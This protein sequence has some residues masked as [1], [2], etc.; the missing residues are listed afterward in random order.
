MNEKPASLADRAFRVLLRLLP[1]DIR[2][3]HGREMEQLFRAQRREIGGLRGLLCLWSETVQDVLTTAPLEHFHVLRQDVA[4]ALRILR[5]APGFTAAATITFA[6]GIGGATSV[7]TVVNAFVFRPLPVHRPGELVSIAALDSHF[8]MPHALSYPDLQDY[9]RGQTAFSDI[10]GFEPTIVWVS[11][12]R[13]SERVL[14]DAVTGNYFPMLGLAPAAGRLIS[15][16]DARTTGDSPVIVLTYDYWQR[17]F[18]GDP[19]VVGRLVRVNGQALTVIGIVEEGFG[20]ANPLVRISAFVPVSMLDVLTHTEA[21]GTPMLDDRGQEGLTLLGRLA[22]GVAIE[23]ARAGLQIVTERLAAEYPATNAGRS[24]L[25]VP[26]SRAR[27]HPSNGPQFRVIAAIFAGLSGLLLVIASANIATMLL[28]RATVRSREVA[29]RSALG[30]R[31]GRVV[32]QFLTESLVL[33][34]LG[35]AAAIPLAFA[36]SRLLETTLQASGLPVPVGVDFSLDWRVIAVCWAVAVLAGMIAGTAPALYA[37]RADINALLKV[38]GFVSSGAGG[39]RIQR[40]LIVAQI[41]VSLALLIFGGLFARTLGRAQEID[42]GFRADG[43]TLAHVD[44]RS[45]GYDEARRRSY[46]RESQQRIATLPGVRRASWA[47]GLPFGYSIGFVPL[48]VDGVTTADGRPPTALTMSVDPEYLA[49]MSIALRSGR[50]FDP[51]DDERSRPVAIVNEALARQLWPDSN[52]IG[53]RVRLE[54]DGPEIEIVGVVANTKLIMLWESPRPLLL[55]PLAQNPSGSAVMQVV[56]DAP[57]AAVADAVRRTLQALDQSVTP[58]DIQTISR[59]L[60]GANG[61]FLFRVGA[62]IAGGFGLLG[63]LL[64]STGV[65]GVMACYVTQRTSEFGVRMAMGADRGAILRGVLF[66]GARLAVTGT[67]FGLLAAAVVARFLRVVLLGVN[68]FDPVI[69]TTLS[70]VLVAVCLLAAFVPAW[71][72]TAVDPV[73]A[74]RA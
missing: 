22:P 8:E 61:F 72:A 48:Q 25:V 3:D 47:S 63:L 23:Q 45:Q 53:R 73:E 64:A 32:R 39:M 68:P 38:G 34:T 21:R 14:V 57:P 20:G 36:A 55:R 74:L 11:D 10:V 31:R 13:S 35:G 52:P 2:A 62:A 16:D 56:A 12:G 65:Y 50:S 26:E 33:A 7:F 24:L 70:L 51:R 9:R 60:G 44:L 58:Y 41:A 37:F 4:Y 6:V 67:A 42:L 18:G 40:G 17:R 1:W 49:A 46:F 54:L 28:A 59:Y 66:R 69:Y 5:R 71:R 29:L 27:P 30:A 15:V 43:V 19:A